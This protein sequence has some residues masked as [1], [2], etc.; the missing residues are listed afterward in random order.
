MWGSA[1]LPPRRDPLAIDLD[2][3][4]IETVGVSTSP[5][6]FDHDAD[7]I[8]TATGW[9][10]GGRRLARVDRNANGLIDS[11]RELF[12]VDTLIQQTVTVSGSQGTYS[13]VTTRN[14]ESGFDAL[15]SLDGNGDGVFDADDAAFAQV[16]LWRDANQD[17]VS[18]AESS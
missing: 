6:F 2:G 8:R 4:G 1:L 13:Y 3:D 14:A 10:P 16:R 5:I 15:Q 18:R 17:G 12:G 7:G 9:L 11:G